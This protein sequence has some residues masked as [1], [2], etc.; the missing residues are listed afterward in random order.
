MIPYTSGY[1]ESGSNTTNVTL[2]DRCPLDP[3]EHIGISYDP[4]AL[5]WVESALTRKGPADPSLK[6]VCL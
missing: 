1:L 6:P 3:V 4:V 5:Q 2:Q